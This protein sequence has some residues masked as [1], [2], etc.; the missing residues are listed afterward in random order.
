MIRRKVLACFIAALALLV[1]SQRPVPASVLFLN[2]FDQSLD[3]DHSLYGEAAATPQGLGL[4]KEGQG[5]PFQGATAPRALDAGYTPLDKKDASVRYPAVNL[6]SRRGTIEMWVKTSWDADLPSTRKTDRFNH[7]FSAPL[8]NKGS[9]NLYYACYRWNWFTPYIVFHLNN[10]KPVKAGEQ[11]PDFIINFR[12]AHDE[13]Q[14]GFVWQ[15]DTWHYLVA[16]WTPTVFRLFADGKLMTER[17]WEKPVDIPPV[18]GPIC[19]GN[20]VGNWGVPTCLAEALIDDVR[21]CDAPLYA[22]EKTIPVPTTPLAKEIKGAT[23]AAGGFETFSRPDPRQYYCYRTNAPPTIDGKLDD[24]VWQQLPIWSGFL[25]YGK[26][27]HNMAQQTELRL[28]RDDKNIYVGALLREDRLDFLKTAAQPSAEDPRVFADD[29]VEFYFAPRQNETPDVQIGINSLNA[30]CDLMHTKDKADFKWNGNAKSATGKTAEGWVVELAFPYDDVSTASP[31]VGDIWGFRAGRNHAGSGGLLS[32][33]NYATTGFQNPLEFARLIMSGDLPKLDALSEENKLN[34]DYIARLRQQAITFVGESKRQLAFA[35]DIPKATKDLKGLTPL[36]EQVQAVV[37]EA[38]ALTAAKGNEPV[39]RWNLLALALKTTT[40]K[41]DRFAY[42]VASVGGLQAPLPP[43]SLIGIKQQGG[44]WYLASRELAAAIDPKRG[45]VAGVWDRTTGNKLIVSGYYLYELQTKK[46][47]KKL[48]ERSDRVIKASVKGERLILECVNPEMP[49]VRLQKQYSLTTV[50]NEPRLLCRR[51]QISGKVKEMTL[52]QT[53]SRTLFDDDYRKPSFYNRIFVIG[54]MG[55]GRTCVPASEITAPSIQ[56]AWF[57]STEGRAQFSLM[58]PQTGSGVAEYLYKENGAWSFPQALAQSYWTPFGWDMGAGATFVKEKP[59]SAELRYHLFR[60]DRLTFH[61]E[62]IGLPEYSAVRNDFTPSPTATRISAVMGL[63]SSQAVDDN[64]STRKFVQATAGSMKE[65]LRP[66]EYGLSAWGPHDTRWPDLPTGDDAEL[67]QTHNNNSGVVLGRWPAKKVKDSRERIRQVNPNLLS[68]N[69]SFIV[70]IYKGSQTFKEHP[71]WFLIT[72]D[73]TPMEG[74][75][76]TEYI[77]ANWCPAFVKF[78]SERLLATC[79]YYGFDVCYLDYGV[80]ILTP[81]WGRG[82]V[83]GF[84]DYLGFIKDLQQ[85]L[86]KRGKL[87]WLNSFVGQPY[88]D[89]GYFEGSGANGHYGITWRDGADVD[90]MTKF[91][92][93]P[94]TAIMPIYWLGGDMFKEQGSYNEVR[95]VDSVLINGLMPTGCWLDPYHIH[96][97]SK[98][99]GADWK[100]IYQYTAAVHY[101]AYEMRDSEWAEVGLKPAWWRD[102]VTQLQVVTLCLRPSAGEPV[103]GGAG[104]Q[105]R[106]ATRHSPLDT[107]LVNV[108]S[109]EKDTKDVNLSVDVKTMGFDPGKRVFVWQFLR[110]DYSK[111]PKGVPVPANW[112]EMFSS[113][114]CS[115]SIPGKSEFS[116]TI[117]QLPPDRVCITALTQTPAAIVSA[118]GIPTQMLLPATLHCR[119]TGTEDEQTKRVTLHVSCDKD[120][121]VIAWWPKA[122][123]TP[124]VMV[125]GKVLHGTP[126]SFGTE[127]FVRFGLQK[128]EWE[129]SVAPSPAG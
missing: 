6:D 48:D 15:K 54:T 12:V 108:I 64:A 95:Y 17:V 85:E 97:P 52:L 74:F 125:G 124:Q 36:E 76:G 94:G 1:R 28:C 37:R 50:G 3:A 34:S 106:P 68:N 107:Y 83:L 23:L 127:D 71:E 93:P 9:I 86:H 66:D 90:M 35:A 41:L 87:L 113:R 27:D 105:G 128:G 100:S 70:D 101:A 18:A 69:Y 44:V 96:F 116:Y 24:A 114:V 103:R 112:N 89:L 59:Y 115:S 111:Y 122:W 39:A 30:H 120:I 56:R 73:G 119:I 45:M 55:D 80:G 104:E 21:I 84:K 81:D 51:L 16:T 109:H 11:D 75:F 32:A 10:G 8:E 33:V 57:N 88:F 123:G 2:H 110:R 46:S 91:Y 99:G 62:Y 5:Y 82:E 14:E 31:K 61:R 65:L 79:D 29:C 121:E 60:G 129:I 47:E 25:V 58:N 92:M 22:N 102:P 13:K 26:H 117:P 72:R 98:E 7:F 118:S 43:A 126:I 63:S 78:L 42:L 4:S 53:T 49:E 77:R 20:N 38:G 19:I 67:V 40:E